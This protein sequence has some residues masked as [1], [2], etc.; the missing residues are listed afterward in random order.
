MEKIVGSA[1]R[2]IQLLMFESL[3]R[4]DPILNQ[5]GMEALANIG[6]D[7]VPALILDAATSDNTPYR[8]RLLRVIEEIG[9]MTDRGDQRELLRLTRDPDTRVQ[10]AAARALYAVGPRGPRRQLLAATPKEPLIPGPHAK[11]G[12][13]YCEQGDTAT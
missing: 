1:G 6:R 8:I 7:A 2:A 4:D 10:T 5:L 9:E 11:H 3:K 12:Q 13:G